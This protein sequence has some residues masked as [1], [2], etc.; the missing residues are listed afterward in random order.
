MAVPAFIAKLGE[1][2][3]K[4]SDRVLEFVSADKAVD[5]INKQIDPQMEVYRQMMTEISAA[6]DISTEKKVELLNQIAE[7][8]DVQQVHANEKL[9]K[10]QKDAS[11]VAIKV[12]GAIFTAG[13]SL[14][15]ELIRR[16]KV[17]NPQI[18]SEKID[19][20][21]EENVPDE[22]NI[23]DMQEA[24]VRSFEDDPFPDEDNMVDEEVLEEEKRL[25]GE[26]EP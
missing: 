14:T 9:E 6:E 19:E 23:F 5:S 22:D 15:P 10:R 8:I 24:P 20:L 12:I 7:N 13:I 3:A 11:E 21:I 26:E 4:L 18:E 1:A 17:A 25:E 2:M 16:F